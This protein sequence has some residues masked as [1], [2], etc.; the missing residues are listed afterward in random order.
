MLACSS[1]S[2]DPML[3]GVEEAEEKVAVEVRGIVRGQ[4]IIGSAK[5]W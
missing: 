3:S 2:K 1:T 4:I 5:P